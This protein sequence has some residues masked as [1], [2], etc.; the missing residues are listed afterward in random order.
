MGSWWRISVNDR[1]F[2]LEWRLQ[3]WWRGRRTWRRC[4]SRR[5]LPVDTGFI[6]I[7]WRLQRWG[8]GRE[9]IRSRQTMYCPYITTHLTRLVMNSQVYNDQT[10]NGHI[11][12]SMH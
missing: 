8:R 9:L 12:K 3:R 4:G 10:Y 6:H 11:N 5:W 1:I 7:E 2:H